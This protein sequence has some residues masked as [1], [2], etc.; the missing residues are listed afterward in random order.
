MNVFELISI[1]LS[2]T[3]L[4]LF[5]AAV[6]F[7]WFSRFRRGFFVT[8]TLAIVG[9]GLGSSM[10]VGIWG[11]KSA[12]QIMSEETLKELEWVGRL[13]EKEL[14]GGIKKSLAQM[15]EL[16][17]VLAPAIKRGD[18]KEAQDK[19]VNLL[20]LNSRFIQIDVYDKSGQLLAVATSGKATE[21]INRVAAAFALDGL[22]F[23]SDPYLSTVFGKH[24]LYLSVPVQAPEGEVIG[25]LSTRLDLEGALSSLL[26]S[27][28]FGESGYIVLVNDDGLVLAH[29][30]RT[31]AREDVSDVPGCSIR[32]EGRQRFIGRYEPGRAEAAFLLQPVKGPGTINPKPMLL[33]SEMDESEASSPLRKAAIQACLGHGADCSCLPRYS[34]TALSLHQTAI[35]GSSAHR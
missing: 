34:S 2:I 8:L 19:T 23:T 12:K 28:Q 6:H 27:T 21:P 24:V 1:L 32:P 4:A 16:S 30:D 14:N 29:P 10:L 31:R 15:S 7:R 20:K 9:T 13:V 33:I 17:A 25:S 22:S 11:Y 26:I 35:P 18:L 3:G 5:V